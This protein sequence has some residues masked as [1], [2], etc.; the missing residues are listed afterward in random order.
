MRK[1]SPSIP[2]AVISSQAV[3]ASRPRT[4]TACAH[5]PHQLTEILQGLLYLLGGQGGYGLRGAGGGSQPVAV[6]IAEHGVSPQRVAGQLL[7]QQADDLH[8]GDILA[9]QL[10]GQRDAVSTHGGEGHRGL[11]KVG[12]S[13]TPLPTLSHRGLGLVPPAG[14]VPRATSVGIGGS[15]A[16]WHLGTLPQLCPA[17]PSAPRCLRAGSCCHLLA[18]LCP[19]ERS[20]G[21]RAWDA[22]WDEGCWDNG[23]EWGQDEGTAQSRPSPSSPSPRGPTGTLSSTH[24]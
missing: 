12:M 16:G 9:A 24:L 3:V 13:C 22:A 20:W 17:A 2:L 1:S 23:S 7:A 8:L 11:W 18:T 14:F 15:P 4:D 6:V 5:H 21:R 10:W 19:A